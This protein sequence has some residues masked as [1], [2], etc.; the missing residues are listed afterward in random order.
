MAFDIERWNVADNI[1]W[2]VRLLDSGSGIKAELY[3][4]L[5]DAQ[6]QTNLQAQGTSAGFSD[7]Y[8][9]LT[10]EPTADYDVDRYQTMYNW[11]LKAS[12]SSGDATIIKK[13][14]KFSQL[15]DITDPI[16]K[17][18]ELILARGSEEI[19]SHVHVQYQHSINLGTMTVISGEVELGEIIKIDSTRIGTRLGQ[20][21]SLIISGTESSLDV[22]IGVLQWE[23]MQRS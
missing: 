12:G 8:I 22:D 3:D 9:Q 14:A 13:V 10:A 18:E 15:E 2:F 5:T 16:Y 1:N 17:N 23:L 6:N 19:N 4:T 7:A 21:D 20:M 11:H